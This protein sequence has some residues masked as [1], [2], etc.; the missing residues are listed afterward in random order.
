[1]GGEQYFINEL[2]TLVRALRGETQRELWKPNPDTDCLNR[3]IRAQA[4]I[5]S[6]ISNLLGASA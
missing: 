5:E 6:A 1:M 4:D 2:K 3:L